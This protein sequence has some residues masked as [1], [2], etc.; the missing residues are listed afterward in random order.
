[1]SATNRS[2]VRH[3]DDNYVT[4]DWCVDALL[5]AVPP[6]REDMG[7]VDPGCGS[8]AILDALD[9]RGPWPLLGVE[10]NS[11]RAKEAEAK[12]HAV[13]YRDFLA[14]KPGTVKNADAVIM[15]PPYKLAIDF[16]GAAIRMC[17]SFQTRAFCIGWEPGGFVAALLRLSFLE[18]KSRRL[19]W[20]H[21]PADVY[22]LSK[23]P[24]F[25]GGGTDAAAYAWFVWGPGPRG[26]V[27]VL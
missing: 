25:T 24:S 26:R 14:M 4:P 17:S 7:I 10:L 9:A 20:H 1:M 15:N 11:E 27:T 21:N 22:V 16:V 19:F 6:M 18:S 2:D 13:I 12:G 3:P 8:G 23:R 5:N